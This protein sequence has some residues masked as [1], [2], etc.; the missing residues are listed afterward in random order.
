MTRFKAGLIALAVLGFTGGFTLSK[1][2]AFEIPRVTFPAIEVEIGLTTPGEY[3]PNGRSEAGEQLVMVYVGKKNCGWSSRDETIEA[4]RRIRK[5]LARTAADRG[6]QF[7]SI[8][9]ATDNLTSDG[10]DH[11]ERI[12][13]FDQVAAGSSYLNTASREYVVTELRGPVS[14]PQ[15]AV[16]RRV[17]ERPKPGVEESG[18]LRVVSQELVHRKVGFYQLTQWINRGAPIPR[19]GNS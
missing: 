8:G 6:M 14:T 7:H 19:T 16:V 9:V 2:E 12:G 18:L 15:V 13:G 17:L 4:V 10:L 5:K 11:L 3:V 1:L